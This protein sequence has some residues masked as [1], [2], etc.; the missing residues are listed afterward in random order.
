MPA[1]R[2]HIL[3]S[4]AVLVITTYAAA[5]GCQAQARQLDLA[6]HQL[7]NRPGRDPTP[8][9]S[10]ADADPDVRA[11]DAAVDERGERPSE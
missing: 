1:S 9:I 4:T 8:V 6:F 5:C 7:N 3:P 2:L 10:Q 11:A